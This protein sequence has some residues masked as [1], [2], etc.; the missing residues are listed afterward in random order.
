MAGQNQKHRLAYK[1]A[2]NGNDNSV[3]K[4]P[5]NNHHV[6]ELHIRKDSER[7]VTPMYPVIKEPVLK[8]TI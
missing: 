7:K 2:R 3:N 8:N 6:W 4:I 1:K 5:Q